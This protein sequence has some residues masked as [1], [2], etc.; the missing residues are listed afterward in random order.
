LGS[1]SPLDDPG[2][3]ALDDPTSREDDEGGLAAD[4]LDDLD[5]DVQ[6]GLARSI[7]APL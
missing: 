2:K 3:R 5:N 4:F 7:R 6:G 1:G